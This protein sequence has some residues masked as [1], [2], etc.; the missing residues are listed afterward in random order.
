[1][2]LFSV[3]TQSTGKISQGA[4]AQQVDE[5]N[6]PQTENLMST[7]SLPFIAPP[8]KKTSLAKNCTQN[9]NDLWEWILEWP[10]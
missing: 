9:K 7:K 1:M 10:F 4:E 8:K 3:A 6:E 2:Y 5:E